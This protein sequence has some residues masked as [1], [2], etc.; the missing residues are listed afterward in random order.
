MLIIIQ[1][2]F[3]ISYVTFCSDIEMEIKDNQ[4]SNSPT[5]SL[6]KIQISTEQVEAKEVL[7]KKIYRNFSKA[8]LK[9]DENEKI[10]IFQKNRDLLINFTK[11]KSIIQ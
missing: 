4:E 1:F 5:N 9:K 11:L 6:D 3:E 8:G 2:L 10:I 7:F